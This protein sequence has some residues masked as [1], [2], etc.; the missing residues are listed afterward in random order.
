M[1]RWNRRSAATLTLVMLVTQAALLLTGSALGRAPSNEFVLDSPSPGSS[2]AGGAPFC[3]SFGISPSS[4][5]VPL[6]VAFTDE[7]TG[8]VDTWYWSFG[9]G[10][11]SSAQNPT[12]TFTSPGTWNV[13]LVVGNATGSYTCYGSVT[14]NSPT[15]PSAPPPTATPAPSPTTTPSPSESPSTEPTPTASPASTPGTRGDIELLGESDDP[16]PHFDIEAKALIGRPFAEAHLLVDAS[17]LEPFSVIELEMRSEPLA[18]GSIVVGPTGSLRALVQ[19]PD[20]VEAGVHSFY[21]RGIGAPS[22]G[23]PAA[24]ERIATIAVSL[25][26]IVLGAAQDLRPEPVAGSVPQQ[27]AAA[28]AGRDAVTIVTTQQ[29]TTLYI[30]Q[31]TS[32]SPITAAIREASVAL[33]SPAT[34]S[35]GA[36]TVLLLA[37]FGILLEL[38]FNLIQERAKRAYAAI[39]SRFVGDQE[40]AGPAR[41]FGMRLD[42][43]LF[44]ALGQVVV[45]LNAPLESIPAAPQLLQAA[46]FGGLAILGIS[47]WYALPQVAMQRRQHR[48][49]GDFR[50]EWPSL[51]LALIALVVAHIVGV[52]PG[53][54]IGLFTVRKFRA[55]LPDALTARGAWL[56]TMM[57][58]SLS[59]LSWLLMDAIDARITDATLPLRVVADGVLGVVVVA[60]SH[61]ALLTLLDPGDGGARALRHTSLLAWLS[62]VAASGL[63]SFA[64]VVTAQIDLALFAP[65]ERLEEYLALL[66]FAIASLG[67]MLALQRVAERRRAAH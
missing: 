44:V 27:P 58:V 62:A 43:L 7:S 36:V 55:A 3:T 14:V 40:P 12:H 63:L 50:A 65:P 61:G 47:W 23:L 28:V 6:T 67:A 41:I 49:I 30:D 1:R 31:R 8:V 15:L 19:L 2:E 33:T 48:D 10:N 54:L 60:G 45:Q 26:G 56:A 32:T 5:T 24:L 9:D 29:G 34:F 18:I 66:A 42:V 22:S 11:I 13:S 53:F 25:D 39:I 38:P 37:L 59:L 57:L 20:V 17:G 46:L 4:G 35:G 52:V 16:T 51:L 21:V 64:L